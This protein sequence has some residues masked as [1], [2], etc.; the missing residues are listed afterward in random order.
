MR[1]NRKTSYNGQANKHLRHS[2]NTFT[3]K[4]P[5]KQ[6]YVLKVKNF[7]MKFSLLMALTKLIWC[8]LYSVLIQAMVHIQLEND[9]ISFQNKN[10]S[11][12]CRNNID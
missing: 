10:S 9:S 3:G 2:V 12:I 11:Q 6:N 4:G 5:I 7:G 8:K 1:G